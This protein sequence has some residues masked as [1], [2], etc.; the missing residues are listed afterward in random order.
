MARIGRLDGPS[1]K[2]HET[3]RNFKNLNN[4]ELYTKGVSKE[5]SHG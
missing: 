4:M 2:A 1:L 3:Y 5:I